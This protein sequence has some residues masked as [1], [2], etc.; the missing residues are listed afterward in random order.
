MG[1]VVLA[2][3][4]VLALVIIAYLLGFFGPR[5]PRAQAFGCCG[6]T[7]AS[8]SASEAKKKECKRACPQGEECAV[9][10]GKE[11]CRKHTADERDPWDAPAR[12]LPRSRPS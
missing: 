1:A 8:A 11:W 6:F 7:S 9:D 12:P 4:I 2:I 10:D 3:T 5:G